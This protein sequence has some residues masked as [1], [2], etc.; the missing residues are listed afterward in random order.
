[1]TMDAPDLI[2]KIVNDHVK[3]LLDLSGNRFANFSGIKNS[4]NFIKII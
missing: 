3:D 4:G 1:M 2:F